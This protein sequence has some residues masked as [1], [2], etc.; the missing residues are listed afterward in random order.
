MPQD[1]PKTEQ[2]H[3]AYLMKLLEKARLEEKLILQ[4]LRPL[5]YKVERR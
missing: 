1:N 2:D 5:I 4:Q 3:I